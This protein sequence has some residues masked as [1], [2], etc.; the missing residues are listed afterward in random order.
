MTSKY[1]I[2]RLTMDELPTDVIFVIIAKLGDVSKVSVRVLTLVSKKCRQM[3]SK[4]AINNRSIARPLTCQNIA[5]E[6]SLNILKWA[7]EMGYPWNHLV[8]T[9]AAKMGHL[10][11]LNW[12]HQNGLTF[13]TEFR[14]EAAKNGHLEVLE[15]AQNKG[16]HLDRSIVEVAA[17]SGHLHILKWFH[18]NGWWDAIN[19]CVCVQAAKRG[20]LDILKWARKE[21]YYWDRFVLM[22]AIEHNNLNIFSWAIENGCEYTVFILNGAEQQWPGIDL[23]V[24]WHTQ[25][26]IYSI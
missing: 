4:Y 22:T 8:C 25:Q 9:N 15:W 16:F 11:I 1:Y 2:I 14:T 19:K 18:T 24:Y 21:E 6:G 5:L 23:N 3:A 26:E 17:T 12:A 10:D 7:F 20:Y 13:Y